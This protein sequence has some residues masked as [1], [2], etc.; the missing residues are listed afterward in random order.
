MI[1]FSTQ[2]QKEYVIRTFYDLM[3]T[4]REHPEL[5]FGVRS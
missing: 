4:L 3:Q 5:R 2:A 1:P